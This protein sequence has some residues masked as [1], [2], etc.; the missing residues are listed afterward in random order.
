MRGRDSDSGDFHSPSRSQ[1]KRDAEAVLGLAEQLVALPAPQLARL[2]L[3]AQIADAVNDTR[4]IH[5]HIARKRQLHFLAKLMRREDDELLDQL[6]SQLGQ[7]RSDARRETAQLHRIEQW[8][9]RLLK[10][11]DTAIGDLADLYP[12]IDRHHLRQLIR[13]AQEEHLQNKPPKA[14]REIFQTLKRA[15]EDPEARDDESE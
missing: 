3:P 4:R 15:F 7:D 13:S 12:D 2:T 6:R 14:F 1:R 11:G 10:Q 8:R 9:D 5:S